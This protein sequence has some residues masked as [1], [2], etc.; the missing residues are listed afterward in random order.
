MTQ[1][2]PRTPQY[3]GPE[4]VV[5]SHLLE[6]LSTG[7]GLKTIALLFILVG[8]GAFLGG[9]ARSALSTLLPGRPGTFAANVVGSAV[10][11]FSAALPVLWPAFLG[12]GFAGAV[13]TLSTMAKE[14]GALVRQKQW[15]TLTRYVLLT[16]TVGIVAAWFGLK[17]GLRIIS[18]L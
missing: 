11:G 1:L 18:A 15:W 13:S 4:G 3:Q 17:Y 10:A 8:F 5:G 12:A 6:A 14:M 9:M 7:E 16:C 2:N